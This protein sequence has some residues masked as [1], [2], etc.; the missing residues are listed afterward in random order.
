MQK[1]NK[2]K[3]SRVNWER[4]LVIG[5]KIAKIIYN[6]ICPYLFFVSTMEILLGCL[7][8]IPVLQG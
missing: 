3:V 5:L 7:F 1:E 2:K 8:N 4:I 6:N